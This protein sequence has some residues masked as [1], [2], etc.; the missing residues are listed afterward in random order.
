MG[1]ETSHAIWSVSI[2]E[3]VIG[4]QSSS[5]K[6]HWPST[7]ST[8]RPSLVLTCSRPPGAR[9]LLLG[10][11]PRLPDRLAADVEPYLS[12]C[13]S[14]NRLSIAGAMDN[15]LVERPLPQPHAL[16]GGESIPAWAGKPRRPWSWSR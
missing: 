7:F 4:C 3:F 13:A 15:P 1:R 6:Y 2:G 9:K 14:L 12:H 11:L 8:Q 5:T 16:L 10:E